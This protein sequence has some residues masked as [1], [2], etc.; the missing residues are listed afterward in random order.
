MKLTD[1][2]VAQYANR[3]PDWGYQ[4]GPNSLGQL[5][6]HR[7]Y[8]RL[9]PDGTKEQW[10]ETVRRVV[11]GCYTLQQQ[12]AQQRGIEFDTDRAQRSMQ[13]MY[14]RCWS[15]KFTPSGRGL[16]MMGT[17]YM[18]ANG[19]A[20]LQN[21][22]FISTAVAD[23]PTR[24]YTWLM[25][26]S[27]LGV[28]VGFDT[29]GAGQPV[30]QPRADSYGYTIPDSR[31]G[32]VES[33]RL[34]LQ[35]YFSADQP[36]VVFSYDC[37]RGPGE[38]IRG[39]GGISSGPG[40]LQQLHA[41]LWIMLDG[42][43]VLTTRHVVDLQNIIGACVVSGNIRRSAEISLGDLSDADFLRL[44]S[45][46]ADMQYRQSWS[47]VSNNSLY[48]TPGMQY[49]DELVQAIATNGE[50]GL[51]YMQNAQQYGRM[52]ELMHDTGT[53]VNPCAEQIL[54]SGELCNLVETY[55]ARHD[56]YADY[57]E[58]LKYAYLFAKSVTLLDTHDP[59]SN[60]VM[61]R[62][63][64][65]GVSMSGIVDFVTQHDEQTLM[66]WADAGYSRL[67][68]LD[69]RVSEWLQVA[70]SI[71]LTTVKPSGSVSLLTG[72]TAGV[73]YPTHRTYI[74]RL[75]IGADDP[76]LPALQAAGYPTE[77]DTYSDNTWVVE[78]PIRGSNVPTETEVDLEQK[79]RL[80][81]LMSKHWSDN[82]VS[83]TLTFRPDEHSKIR[84]VLQEY[85]TQ[86]KSIS[87]LPITPGGAYRQMP[88]E[89]IS[90]AEYERRVRNLQPV[91]LHGGI[92]AAGELYCT[93]DKCELRDVA[94]VAAESAVSYS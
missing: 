76:L 63:R 62:N 29:L 18:Y 37:I 12:H 6:Y 53:G 81:A 78:L 43:D 39:F 79:A 72:A 58:T 19:S 69:N 11:E 55:P 45:N 84:G 42:I 47:W 70:R 91:D 25:D 57:A 40:P 31:E 64:R 71:R 93:T 8:A 74:R 50:P 36:R 48:A 15:F 54:E 26:M 86:W 83:C 61:Q 89:A 44:K 2:F 41:R 92:E 87:L 49:T 32:W 7:T 68:Q 75:R 94:V 4:S 9:L 82:A 3:T 77:L 22:A 38:P 46:D 1:K 90:D 23:D 34:L 88:Y 67:R 56:D 65:I 73:H 80:A 17:Q 51:V 59:L 35:S 52:G 85:D 14:D 60:A 27:M 33:V 5:T 13:Q 30:H 10:H 21:C 28:G 20:A 66:D 24:P 16:W